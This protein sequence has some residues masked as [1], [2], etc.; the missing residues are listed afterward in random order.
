VAHCP[1][2]L[3][4]NNNNHIYIALWV[5]TSEALK[6][7][8]VLMNGF[9]PQTS[10]RTSSQM[11]GR[12]PPIRC[13]T[14]YSR[15]AFHTRPS[16]LARS[17]QYGPPKQHRSGRTQTASLI[18]V[19]MSLEGGKGES[20]PPPPRP[21]RDGRDYRLLLLLLLLKR[22]GMILSASVGH[23]HLVSPAI[24]SDSTTFPNCD[25]P[26]R[27]SSDRRN[28]TCFIT[29]HDRFPLLRYTATRSNQ[30]CIPPGSL[31]RVPALLG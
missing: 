7:S 31:N 22:A 10:R 5:V 4:N 6:T 3:L 11:F 1:C 20:N 12:P 25:R 9:C 29:T 27:T 2:I 15:E 18:D 23:A 8:K 21:R 19:F 14:V 17:I 16:M 28:S 24:G 26:I 30:P 13:V